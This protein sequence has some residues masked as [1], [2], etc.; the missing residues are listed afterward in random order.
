MKLCCIISW[1]LTQSEAM[2]LYP[3]SVKPLIFKWKA[4]LF[5]WPLPLSPSL[6]LGFALSSGCC[7]SWAALKCIGLCDRNYWLKKSASFELN[8]FLIFG[9]CNRWPISF[10]QITFLQYLASVDQNG[11]HLI[12]S[13]LLTPPSTLST[14]SQRFIDRWQHSAG[15]IITSSSDLGFTAL[16]KD[17]SACWLQ[18]C[19]VHLQ[20]KRPALSVCSQATNSC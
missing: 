4:S 2:S 10:K 12:W 13:L 20:I 5:L 3:L 8:S 15:T 11:L 19:W 1:H 18:I 16:L 6:P 14:H 17:T 9:L 7:C